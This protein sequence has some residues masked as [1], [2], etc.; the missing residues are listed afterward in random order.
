VHSCGHL[1]L[2]EPIRT[3]VL[4]LISLGDWKHHSGA[5]ASELPEEAWTATVAIVVENGVPQVER[6]RAVIL[7]LDRGGEDLT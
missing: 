2:Q 5:A 4:T 6:N 1:F 3:I 7:L